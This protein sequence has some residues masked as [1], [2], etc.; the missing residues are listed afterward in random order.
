MANQLLFLIDSYQ[1]LVEMLRIS[2]CQF[3]YSVNP[4]LFQQVGILF[5]DALDTKEIDVVDPFQDQFLTNT[6]FLGDFCATLWGSAFF[7]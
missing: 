7:Q 2:L 6:C 5:T 3:G 1:L 4:C